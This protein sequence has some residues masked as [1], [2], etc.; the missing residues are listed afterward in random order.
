S[1]VR[2]GHPDRRAAARAAARRRRDRR[3][4]PHPHQLRPE[5]Q[6]AR[7]DHR[8]WSVRELHPSRRRTAGL[9]HRRSGRLMYA[10][11]WRILPGPA[12]V[13]VLIL[14]VLAAAVVYGL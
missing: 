4:V 8:L 11:L 12:W 9:A 7:A 3:S 13:R 1:R 10:A 6:H 14:L 2:A 5:A